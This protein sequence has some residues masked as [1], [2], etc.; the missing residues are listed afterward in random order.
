MRESQSEWVRQAQTGDQEAFGKLVNYYQGL[1][2]GWA[3]HL[4]GDFAE[5]EDTVQDVFLE[6]YLCLSRLQDFVKFPS[7]L[8]QMTY[9]HCVDKLRRRK[10]LTS[11]EEKSETDEMILSDVQQCYVENEPHK[12]CEAL[13]NEEQIQQA[14]LQIPENNR[15]VISLYYFSGKSYKEI[16][17]FCGVPVS[18][19]EG[20]L[21]RAKRQ[22]REVL[23]MIQEGMENKRLDE[24][25]TKKVLECVNMIPAI[26]WWHLFDV[27]QYLGYNV[28]IFQ[29]VLKNPVIPAPSQEEYKAIKEKAWESVKASINKGIP[30]IVWQP[31]TLEQ[32]EKG[33]NAYEWAEIIGY[34]S[35]EKTYT[36]RHSY[37]GDYTVPYDSFGFSDPVNWFCII[38]FGSLDEFN[39]IAENMM[40]ISSGAG[41]KGLHPY[42]Q[43]TK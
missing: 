27:I 36:I 31:M 11:L 3:F 39:R 5:A 41:I 16:A 10:Y 29:A 34:N 1:V 28:Q 14:L 15:I 18:T 13:E 40:L 8:R 32:K 20:R 17:E 30:A 35:E 2:H 38:V 19:I 12:N 42:S 43:K 7:W 4:L 37:T 21:Y 25:F 6:A 24:S 33:I 22:L 23:T 26:S 9:H